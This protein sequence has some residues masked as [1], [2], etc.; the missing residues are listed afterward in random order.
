MVSPLVMRYPESGFCAVTGPAGVEG[1]GG[2]ACGGGWPAGKEMAW[3]L[4][5][6]LTPA[7]LVVKAGVGAAA[8]VGGGGVSLI[9]ATRR[10]RAAAA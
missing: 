8:G 10:P 9:E 5:S 6:I 3:P 1:A 7:V 4:A 2:A